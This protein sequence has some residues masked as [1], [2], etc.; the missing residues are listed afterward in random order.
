MVSVSP[1]AEGG[2]RAMIGSSKN[3]TWEGLRSAEI[4]LE[5]LNHSLSE[6]ASMR[7]TSGNSSKKGEAASASQGPN[8][9]A[10]QE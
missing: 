2:E 5:S 4:P 10:R 8:E 7:S 1:D 9:D 6:K 3:S